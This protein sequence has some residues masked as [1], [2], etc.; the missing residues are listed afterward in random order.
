[1]EPPP[2]VDSEHLVRA[3]VYDDSAPERVEVLVVWDDS[4]EPVCL[5][6]E[7]LVATHVEAVVLC[8]DAVMASNLN[9]PAPDWNVRR[10]G[11][12]IPSHNGTCSRL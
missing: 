10:L 5:R 9:L 7:A 4:V 1:M 8:L 11:M 12:I 3:L 6:D 2:G